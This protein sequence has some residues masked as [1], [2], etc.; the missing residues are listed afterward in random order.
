MQRQ[1]HERIIAETID[2][3]VPHVKEVGV[4]VVMQRQTQERIIAETIDV[5][6]PHVKEEIIE[7]LRRIPQEPLVEE[8][9]VPVSRVMKNITEV[10]KHIQQELAQNCTVEQIIDSRR[11]DTTSELWSAFHRSRCRVMW[12]SKLLTSQFHEGWRTQ[13]GMWSTL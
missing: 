6:V 5:S 2:V 4:P 10:V 11:E 9:D 1:T 3:S 12:E 13:V 7:V 8:T